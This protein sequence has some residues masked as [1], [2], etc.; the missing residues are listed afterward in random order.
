[1]KS[2]KKR[3][4]VSDLIADQLALQGC[5]VVF[6]VSGGASLHLLHSIDNHPNLKLITVHHEQSVAMATEAYSRI[7]GKLGVGV[8]TSG[9]GATNLTTGIAG[10]YFDSV[11][12]IFLTGQVSTFRRSKGLGIR[13]YGFQE[14]PTLHIFQSITK[15]VLEIEDS[16]MVLDSIFE[17]FQTAISERP[18]PIVVDIPDNIQREI[19]EVPQETRRFKF[20]VTK[21]ILSESIN[22]DSTLQAVQNLIRT[23]TKPVII[24]G[25]GVILSRMESEFLNLLDT[26]KVPV[27]LTWGAK[28]LIPEDREYLLGTFGTHG[29]RTANRAIQE[30]DLIISFGSRLDT[31]ATGTPTGSFAPE[32]KKVV[33]DVDPN[34]IAKFTHKDVKIEE[35]FVIDFRSL[36]FKEILRRLKEM[37]WESLK[38]DEWQTHIRTTLHHEEAYPTNSRYV[39]PYHFIAKVSDFAPSRCRV[40][41]DT[42]CSIAWAM[43]SWQVKKE[44]TIYHDFNNTA[45]GW[46]IPASL[47]SLSVQDSVLTICIIGDGSLMMTV[48]ELATLQAQ[49]GSLVVF[50]M[51]NSGYSMIKQTQD[52]WF[53]SNYFASDSNTGMAFPNYKILSQAFGFD[54]ALLDNDVNLST[55]EEIMSHNKGKIIVEVL[56]DPFARVIPQNRFGNPIHIMEP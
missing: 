19:V 43:Q 48:G 7:T 34:E 51:N 11:P 24:C 17:A 16:M 29:N 28:H 2:A 20:R 18:G 4:K 52:Q 45:M 54:Y 35:S 31:K 39:N 6:G 40:I 56:I 50:I 42:G 38:D 26:W 30:S 36:N 1:M 13:Q 55:L 53:N 41:V 14:T 46:S 15:K 27:A 44:Q 47:A 8:V 33:F 25:W 49:K 22:N 37:H 32:A 3:I 23:S 9:P 12:C 10:A 21:H 5:D